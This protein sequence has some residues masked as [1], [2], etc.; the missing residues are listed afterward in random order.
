[1]KICKICGKEF[2]KE[3]WNQVYCDK[4]CQRAAGLKRRGFTE[5]WRQPKE[6]QQRWRKMQ[7]RKQNYIKL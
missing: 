1:M 6:V 3:S 2:E 5:I 7:L 4:V